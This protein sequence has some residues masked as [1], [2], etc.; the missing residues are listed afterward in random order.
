MVIKRNSA[1][2]LL[3]TDAAGCTYLDLADGDGPRVE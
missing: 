2:G 3:A 1:A